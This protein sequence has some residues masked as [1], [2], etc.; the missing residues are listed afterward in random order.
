MWGGGGEGGGGWGGGCVRSHEKRKETI[1]S[2]LLLS[3]STYSTS[4]LPYSYM[5]SVLHFANLKSKRRGV[6]GEAREVRETGKTAVRGAC[7]RVV[8]VCG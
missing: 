6:S 5:N 1:E 4:R 7:G 3:N 8:G 2:K